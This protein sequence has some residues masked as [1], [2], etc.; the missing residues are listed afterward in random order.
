MSWGMGVWGERAFYRYFPQPAKFSSLKNTQ[1][2]T[3]NK[4]TVRE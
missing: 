2:S 4:S 1:Q 3:L